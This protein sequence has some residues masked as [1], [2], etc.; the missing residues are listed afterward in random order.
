MT[1]SKLRQTISEYEQQQMNTVHRLTQLHQ[2]NYDERQNSKVVIA[3]LKRDVFFLSDELEHLR[4]EKR[5]D[6]YDETMK[7]K[8]K[9]IQEHALAE[10]SLRQQVKQ[11]EDQAESLKTQVALASQ[12]HESQLKFIKAAH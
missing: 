10:E 1:I 6:Q 12:Q 9:V 4:S 3:Q 8:D 2:A 11:L 7:A 5:A